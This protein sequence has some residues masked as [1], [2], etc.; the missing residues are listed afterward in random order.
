MVR[1]ARLTPQPQLPP[2]SYLDIH[3]PHEVVSEVV[4][5]IH[6]LHLPV[7]LLHFCENL[8]RGER[9]L[10]D[11]NKDEKGTELMSAYSYE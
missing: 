11:H 9:G 3:V 1:Q 7:L 5:D 2:Q 8:L 6:L 4:T 10:E